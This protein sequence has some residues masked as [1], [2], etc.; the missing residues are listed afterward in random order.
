[1]VQGVRIKDHWQEQR[2]FER[3]ALIAGILIIALTFALIGRLV[4]LQ[5]LRQKGLKAEATGANAIRSARGLHSDGLALEAILDLA[6][7]VRELN[8]S[9]AIELYVNCPRLGF[10]SSSVAMTEQVYG[11]RVTWTA[12]GAARTTARASRS[13]TS[14]SRRSSLAPTTRRASSSC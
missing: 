13:G 3:R 5:V 11:P 2:L 6:P 8:G 1:M 14:S 7:I 4:L 12:R 10:E 9:A